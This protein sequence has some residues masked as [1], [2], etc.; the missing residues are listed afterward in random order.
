MHAM[1]QVCKMEDNLWE[2]IFPYTH[3][4]SDGSG[5]RDWQRAPLPTEP[6]C[7]PTHSFTMLNASEFTE[8]AE[9]QQSILKH[10]MPGD[11]AKRKVNLPNHCKEWCRCLLI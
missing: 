4:S 6:L 7:Q 2:L 5:D 10:K 11:L 1:A 3:G 8:L 9:E